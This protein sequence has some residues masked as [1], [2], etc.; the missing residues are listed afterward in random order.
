MSNHEEMMRPNGTCTLNGKKT[1]KG[2]DRTQFT[3]TNQAEYDDIEAY[4][5]KI[6]RAVEACWVAKEKWS[7][8]LA[9]PLT[10]KAQQVYNALSNEHSKDYEKVKE[11]VFQCYAINEK[12]YS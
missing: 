6:E 3:E 12:P 7:D 2:W 4:L 11:E 1:T 5:K 9:P 10:D 8:I